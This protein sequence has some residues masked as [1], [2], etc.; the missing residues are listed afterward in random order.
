LD[1][2]FTRSDT[3]GKLTE[4]MVEVEGEGMRKVTWVMIE[5][6]KQGDWAIGGVPPTPKVEA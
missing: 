2:F 1:T 4:A 5:E 3:V 6:V